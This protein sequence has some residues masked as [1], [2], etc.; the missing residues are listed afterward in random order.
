MEFT[1]LI[2]SAICPTRATSGSAGFD[3][4]AAGPTVVLAPGTHQVVPT[5]V[6]VRLDSG[7]VGLVCPR[8]GLAA[9]C[10]VTVLNGPGIIDSDYE[11][12]LKVILVNHSRDAYLIQ[13]G[14]RIA[15]LIITNYFNDAGADIARGAGGFG[16]TGV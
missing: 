6:G 3:L 11:G 13:P 1:K 12:E 9:K 15:Q 2:E 5:G 10:G 4:Y 8:S 14:E 16:S 7:T